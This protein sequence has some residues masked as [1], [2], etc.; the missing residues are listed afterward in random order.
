MPPLEALLAPCPIKWTGPAVA[1]WPEVFPAQVCNSDSGRVDRAAPFP[2]Q[3]GWSP[4]GTTPRTGIGVDR[5]RRERGRSAVPARAG[6]TQNRDG[7]GAGVPTEYQ[8]PRL[9]LGLC[10]VFLPPFVFP[11]IG[12]GRNIHLPAP[13][14][15]PGSQVVSPARYAIAP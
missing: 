13:S 7:P 4:P 14:R 9:A 15:R 1:R 2:W 10:P 11:P 3:S 8:I 12:L 5:R 6:R